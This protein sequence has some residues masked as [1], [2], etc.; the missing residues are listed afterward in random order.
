VWWLVVLAALANLAG[1]VLVAGPRSW[2]RTAVLKLGALSAGFLLA[3]AM[4]DLLPEALAG[5][6]GMPY[7]IM[8]GFG[9]VYMCERMF[10][11]HFHFGE[12][13]HAHGRQGSAL[14]A[15]TG[16]LVHTF[17]D[18]MAIVAG[19]MIDLRVG[20]LVFAGVMLHKAADGITM[21]SVT[22][23]CH[24]SRSLALV[25]TATLAVATLMGGLAL[26]A[27]ELVAPQ[28]ALA[29]PGG[30]QVTSVALALAGGV[31]LY[32]AAVDLL[33]MVNDAG[34]RS[35]PWYVAAG[36]LCM[37]LLSGLLRAAGAGH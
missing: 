17:F 1:G 35:G 33:P 7:W 16:L 12:E 37:L 10:T 6:S 4:V 25:A 8:G 31:F 22:L 34:L 36:A 18:G 27:L 15:W 14:G 5:G 23:A 32:V 20:I 2:S 30:W 19:F 29:G 26:P 11:T 13:T 3:V 9:L 24:G 21:A 28:A